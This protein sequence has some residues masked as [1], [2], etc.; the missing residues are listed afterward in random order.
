MRG[1]RLSPT[2]QVARSSWWMA[3]TRRAPPITGS[4][5]Q[6]AMEGLRTLVE[7]CT[8]RMLPRSRRAS[9][10]P[11]IW[12]LQRSRYPGMIVTGTEAAKSANRRASVLSEAIGFSHMTCFPALARRS[13]KAG[14]RCGGKARVAASML[15][16]SRS[17]M[18][19]RARAPIAAACAA[20]P[21]PGSTRATISCPIFVRA[22]TWREPAHPSDPKTANFMGLILLRNGLCDRHQRVAAA[23]S[24][25]AGVG[26]MRGSVASVIERKRQPASVRTNSVAQSPT[27]ASRPGPSRQ[28]VTR[29]KDFPMA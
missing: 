4:L 3:L 29:M 7:R 10:N 24:S 11:R 20:Q 1:V 27:A 6:P 14:C 26:A 12:G 13:V 18:E 2:N 25:C 21:A 17:S 9:R 15:S 28:S 16:R 5:R 22:S 23:G 19:A 8:R